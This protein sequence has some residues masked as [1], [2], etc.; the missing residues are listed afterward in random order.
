MKMTQR[1][2]YILSPLEIIQDLKKRNISDPFTLK[3]LQKE[4][5]YNPSDEEWKFKLIQSY[6]ES[7]LL[8]EY[9]K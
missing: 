4:I 2:N 5:K 9:V 1:K 7:D 3:F 6:I 8:Q